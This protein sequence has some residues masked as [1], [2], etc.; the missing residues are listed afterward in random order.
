MQK[1][2]LSN[3]AYFSS[4]D[5]IQ[6]GIFDLN[7]IMRGKRLSPNAYSR[8]MKNGIQLPLSA[9]NI[10][11][12]GGDIENS[13][14]VF[15]TGDKDGTASWQD[16]PQVLLRHLPKP[17]LLIPLGLTNNNGELFEGCP[18]AFL[19]KVMNKAREKEFVFK[20]GVELE[21][22]LFS[23]SIS[24]SILS[25]PQL[26]SLLA[27]DSVDY[28]LADIRQITE[29]LD[30]KIESVLS[31]AGVG[32]IEI[33]LSP[34]KDLCHLADAILLLKHSLTAYIQSKGLFASF[35]A[36]PKK[37]L[38]G[39]GMHCHISMENSRSENLFAKD[40]MLFKA[41]I[42]AS[43]KL[44]EPATAI[45]APLPNS[46]D[47]LRENSHAPVNIGWGF[48]NRTLAIRVPNASPRNKRLEIRVA[49]ADCNP[50]LLFAVLI[51]FI[52]DGIEEML[53]P[54]MP[55]SGNGYKADLKKL[56]SD[57]ESALFIFE[58]SAQ[59]RK[60]FPPT[61]REMFIATKKQ[62][63]RITSTGDLDDKKKQ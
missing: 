22:C 19:K 51:S 48:D 40:E 8:I 16:A 23:D 52:L 37:E 34:C 2:P 36:K 38:A 58:N 15:A 28:F 63:I 49:G 46:Y 6:A 25:E 57:L 60:I 13:D 29:Q 62:E 33:V 47:R 3:D 45:L 26:L 20:C 17:I 35:K 24:T 18:R 27:L 9:Q 39:N 7:G 4:I 61:L 5:H 41:S 54:P 11:I 56:P 43:L 1:N 32:Q 30:V 44:L 50:Y 31:E 14:F 42:A 53:T 55:I 12:Y 10:D 21:L 59:M